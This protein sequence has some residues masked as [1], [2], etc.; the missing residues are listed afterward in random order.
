MVRVVA[1]SITVKTSIVMVSQKMDRISQT[2]VQN[3]KETF[4][5]VKV[6][7]VTGLLASLSQTAK[8]DVDSRTW[9]PLCKSCEHAQANCQAC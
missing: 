6:P 7:G 8:N 2:H 9:F 1:D 4:G 3:I 5:P